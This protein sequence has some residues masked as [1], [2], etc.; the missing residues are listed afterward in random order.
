MKQKNRRRKKHNREN[1][2]E[3]RKLADFVNR[4]SEKE[5]EKGVPRFRCYIVKKKKITKRLLIA[6]LIPNVSII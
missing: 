5:V 1:R 3:A 4:W 2:A 6:L